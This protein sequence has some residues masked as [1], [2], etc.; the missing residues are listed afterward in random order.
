VRLFSAAILTLVI[1]CCA[2]GQTYTIQTFAGGGL[3][4]NIPGTYASLRNPNSLAVDGKGNVFFADGQ[5]VLRLDA[6][7]S[8]LTLVAGNGTPGFSGDNGPATNAQLSYPCGVAVDSAGNLY[9][10][11]YINN[12]IRKVSNGVI[13]TVAG[14]GTLG[15]SGDNGPA[16]NAQLSYPY[17][18]AVDAGGS[19]YIA[20]Q[21]NS[22]I[23]KVSNGVITTVVGNGTEGSSGDNGPATSA[24]LYS[25]L[26]V[27][28]D[29]AGNLYIADFSNSRIRKVSNGVITTVAGNGTGGYSGDNGP[30]TGAQLYNPKG[31]AVDSAGNLYI[32]D[33]GNNRI[34]R[35]S[36]GVITTT[37]LLY[38]P[39]GVAVDSAGNLY[40][41]GNQSIGKVSK[42]VIT[43]VAGGGSAIGDNGPA[44]S[45]QL[46]SPFGVAVDSA[47]NL[48]ITDAY[49]QRIRRV[50]N[51]VITTVAGNGTLGFSGDNGPATNAQLSYPADVA[52]DAAGNLYIADNNRVRKVSNGVITTVAGNG[53]PGFS[54]DNG[55]ATGAQ[56]DF[57]WGAGLAVDSAR[58]L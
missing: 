40:V 45:A 2:F 17:G 21:G 9:I 38:S 11:E 24:Q 30:A 48:Y 7:S 16:T 44:V 56:L 10:A 18:V 3:P 22:R 20:D 12:R 23:R 55:T 51:G 1:S 58:N 46:Y 34:R 26:G 41:A 50:S 31:V 29:S 35:V 36:N 8:V 42:G 47:G 6:T 14:N 53:T 27:A 39:Q 5:V 54:G 32:A 33:A 57:S 13:T 25:P 43:A 49:N 19:L 28:V 52:V 15:Y 4:V 37:A